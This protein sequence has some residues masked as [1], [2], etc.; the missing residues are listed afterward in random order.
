[1]T[2][3]ELYQKLLTAKKQNPAALSGE[4][5][6]LLNDLATPDKWFEAMA[7]CEAAIDAGMLDE[8]ILNL[9][10]EMFFQGKE[11][12]S[13]TNLNDEDYADWFVQLVDFNK[14]L[15]AAG[16]MEAW[17]ELG[18]LYCYARFP[19]RDLSK[20]EEYLLK[21]AELDIPL[22]LALYGYHLFRGLGI[23]KIDEEKGMELMLRA[24]EKNFERA[25]LYL[26]LA[27]FD[28][29]I[30]P[31]VY[32]QKIEDYNATAK[33][34]NQLWFLLGDTYYGKLNDID[35]AIEAYNKG[36]ELNDDPY[37]KY[38]KAIAILNGEIDGDKDE[39]IRM[40]EN[41]YEWNMPYAADFL[42]Q[43]Y[44]LNDDYRNVDKA[45]EW[46]KKA[47]A[48]Y[49]SH[50]MVNLSQ[51]YLYNSE[52]ENVAE[53][54][55]YLDMAI[56]ND[57][58]RALS[59]KAYFLLES[60]EEN[61]NIPLAKELLEKACDAGDGYAA[62]RLGYGYQQAEFSEEQDYQTA[63]K[64]YT[65]GAERNHLYAIESAG[66][67]YRLGVAG[68]TNPE[69]AIEYFR[70][71]AERGS[72][73]ARIELSLCYEEGFGVEQDYNK[74]FELLNLAAADNYYYAHNKLGYYY[75]NGIVDE[76]DL[77][78]AY[79][80][81]AKAAENGIFDAMYNLGRIYKYAIGRP[82]N[83]ELA[84]KYF[85]QAAEGG[86]GDANVE[87][88]ISYEHAYGGLEFD[89]EKATKYMTL[90]AEKGHPYAQYKL[91]TYY[92]YGLVEMDTE[93]GLEYLNYAYENGSPYAAA[94][95]GD[96]LL[97]GMDTNSDSNDAFQYYKYAADKDYITEGIGLCYLYGIGVERNESEAFKYFSIAAGRDYVAAKYRLGLCYKYELGTT[98]NLA[99]A[100]KWISQAA[101]E[102]NRS[103]K[104][105]LAMMLLDGEGVAMNLEKGVEWLHKA[106]EEEQSDAQFELGNCYL[107]GRGVDEDE[108]QAMYWYQKAAENGN[109]KAQKLTGK[110]D[111]RRR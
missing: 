29:D 55:K 86:D 51:I 88:G 68:E 101:E 81:F 45:I 90:A 5:F 87:M 92:Y 60:K 48:Y 65:L 3:K 70:K 32:I 59:E 42:G 54:L 22:A 23:A 10:K 104:Y 4:S 36:I 110:R 78:K 19:Y 66:N 12:H 34:V 75:M 94:V 109:E 102:N 100:Y 28:S 96:H 98:K 76:P 15:A 40:V 61:R 43:V 77:D 99:E 105:E 7:V 73:Y 37:C 62:Y 21:G 74:A 103:A 63:L 9:R 80:Y 39:A 95:L 20:S 30:A 49:N 85:E 67:Y 58:I 38:K 2:F 97:Y 83:P 108:V 46:Y 91:G 106:A 31:D 69:K 13:E 82:E 84:L 18:S 26:F 33:T 72:N 1:M 27:E 6:S 107:T 89:G 53:G 41:A 8:N 11:L 93:K 17:V 25:D 56:E 47:I 24:K 50:A 71:A 79:E 16:V 111:K 64:Y 52:Y 35:K 14:K 44:Y 57:N